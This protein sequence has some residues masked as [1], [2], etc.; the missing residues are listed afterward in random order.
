MIE[1]GLIHSTTSDPLHSRAACT[2]PC[3][4]N[5]HSRAHCSP[6]ARLCE[7]RGTAV[8]MCPAVKRVTREHWNGLIACKYLCFVLQF[9]EVISD[10]HGIDPTGTYHGD[11]D[12]QLE[13][14]NV[15]YNEATGRQRF[16]FFCFHG[17]KLKRSLPL[18]KWSH[19]EI[20]DEISRNII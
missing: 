11:S 20:W 6:G 19:S 12:L 9:W 8:C 18:T 16:F 4:V 10:E 14:I 1:F 5:T 7:Q 17:L 3:N 2:Q 15:Y 13:R